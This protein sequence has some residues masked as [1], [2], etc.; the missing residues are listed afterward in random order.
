MLQF[1]L[2]IS[3]ES[4]HAQIEYLYTHFHEEMLRVAKARL[5]QMSCNDCQSGAEDVV[6]EAWLKITRYISRVDFSVPHEQLR[7]Y[8][9][10]IIANE[11]CD[12]MS[13]YAYYESLDEHEDI[14]S[15][16]DFIKLVNIAQS[17]EFVKNCVAQMKDIYATVMMMYFFAE[18]DVSQISKMLN[19]PQKTV[20]TRLVRGKRE[21]LESLK[22]EDVL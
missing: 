15:D 9:L 11:A 17:Y 10:Q 13:H 14:P 5:R 6:Q 16:E 2:S 1:L 22:D 18:M 7:A 3:D 8:V 20:Y 12:Y 21:L 4:H 19:I